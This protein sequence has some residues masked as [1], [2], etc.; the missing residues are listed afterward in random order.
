MKHLQLFE[1]FG[2]SREKY[3]PEKKPYNQG[4]DWDPKLLKRKV[5]LIWKI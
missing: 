4:D 5:W 1:E 3:D 2:F